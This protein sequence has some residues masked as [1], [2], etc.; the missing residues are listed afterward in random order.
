VAEQCVVAIKGRRYF[1]YKVAETTRVKKGEG[2]A[3]SLRLVRHAYARHP[4][5][6]SMCLPYDFSCDAWRR[7]V[8][9]DEG[10][11]GPIKASRLV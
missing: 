11:I 7:H 8:S 1:S 2:E 10:I 3:L 6:G 9:P 5:L 4:Q